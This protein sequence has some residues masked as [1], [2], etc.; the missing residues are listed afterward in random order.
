MAGEMSKQ[1]LKKGTKNPE[2]MKS[3]PREK[4][5]QKV[6][7]TAKVSEHKAQQLNDGGI[8]AI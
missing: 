6:A 4:T 8:H 5:V 7:A 1:N 2:V 3:L